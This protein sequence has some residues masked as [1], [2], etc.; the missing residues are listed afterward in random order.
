MGI[1][2]MNIYNRGDI[3]DKTKEFM[4]LFT[5]NT[6]RI[7]GSS[8]SLHDVRS[9]IAKPTIRFPDFQ[10]ND[11]NEA[12]GLYNT[13]NKLIMDAKKPSDSLS[14]SYMLKLHKSVFN[15]TKSYAGSFRKLGEEVGIYGNGMLVH[16]GTNSEQVKE[17]LEKLI[18]YHNKELK[19]IKFGS[20]SEFIELAAEFHC[21]FETIHPFLDGNGRVGRLLFEYIL[22]RNKVNPIDITYDNRSDYYG[23]LRMYQIDKNISSFMQF[24]ETEP[25]YAIWD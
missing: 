20:P 23:A 15:K 4:L 10:K 24:L 11:V 22:I 25:H 17:K 12:L 9:L 14:L 6:N 3:M 1:M 5:Y 16:K 18:D 8:L 21:E 19:L 13:I 2:G 7:E